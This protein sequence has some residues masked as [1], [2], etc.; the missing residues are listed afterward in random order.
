MPVAS[1]DLNQGAPRTD[2]VVCF[3]VMVHSD[4]RYRGPP[5]FHVGICSRWISGVHIAGDSI[6]LGKKEQQPALAHP[7]CC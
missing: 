1:T 5:H 7:S 6:S 2:V 3:L 4:H